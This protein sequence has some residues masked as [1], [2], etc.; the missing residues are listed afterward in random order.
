MPGLYS[1]Q[2]QFYCATSSY[3]WLPKEKRAQLIWQCRVYIFGHSSPQHKGEVKSLLS[4]CYSCLVVALYQFQYHSIVVIPSQY[5][6]HLPCRVCMQ[7]QSYCTASGRT[8]PQV[9]IVD[10]IS[11]LFYKRHFQCFIILHRIDHKQPRGSRVKSFG[12]VEF[13]CLAIVP[14][15]LKARLNHLAAQR[16]CILPQSPIT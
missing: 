4:V 11:A 6:W 13:M 14:N 10:E 9:Y 16:L 7:L 3:T 15:N 8:Q 12:N 1:M 2:L 5:Q